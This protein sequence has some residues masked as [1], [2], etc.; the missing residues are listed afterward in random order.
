MTAWRSLFRA[1]P[2]AQPL[3]LERAVL[4]LTLGAA[5]VALVLLRMGG[6]PL[7]HV[8][9]EDGGIFLEQAFGSSF[10]DAVTT[11]YAGYLH[12]VPRLLAEITAALPIEWS[13]AVL[14]LLGSAGAVLCAFIVWKTSAAHLPDPLLRG[15]LSAM[16][17]LLPVFGFETLANVTYLQWL[18]SFATFWLVLWR[19]PSSRVAILAGV[20]VA[21]TV[22]SAPLAL[23]FA[24][25]VLLRAAALRERFDPIVVGFVLAAA[26]QLLAV[27]L[28]TDPTAQTDPGWGWDLLSAYP[29][30]VVSG[31]GLGHNVNAALWEVAPIGLLIMS[32]GAFLGFVAL[33]VLR[34]IPARRMVLVALALSAG[35]YLVAGYGRDLG[36]AL[37]WPRDDPYTYG[38]RYTI[39][40]ALFLLTA[41]LVELGHVRGGSRV[42]RGALAVIAV[43]ALSTFYLGDAGRS[44]VRWSDTVA[45]ARAACAPGIE[46]AYEL[47]VSWPDWRIDIPCARL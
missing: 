2:E 24:P 39:L 40:P 19:P 8:W 15:L 17:I 4:G 11:P 27:V 33:A 31:L 16:V 13:A 36:D 14:A 37:M 45:N 42:R 6:A 28:D 34:P 38:A 47:A 32:A 44:T 20:F 22:L 29:L 3:S 10:L 30:R 1:T 23:L 9:A 12:T 35:T 18:M 41:V 21:L 25:L 7:T 5:A 26:L 43:A 46:T